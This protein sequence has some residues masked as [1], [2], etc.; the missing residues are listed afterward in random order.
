MLLFLFP[1]FVPDAYFIL[2]RASRTAAKKNKAVSGMLIPRI[3][4]VFCVPKSGCPE[5]SSKIE[6]TA[7][8]AAIQE[9]SK[10]KPLIGVIVF[11]SFPPYT[12]DFTA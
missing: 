7:A 1:L 3:I 11:I 12:I 2:A 8:I 5:D 9:P 6:P 10:N 4:A